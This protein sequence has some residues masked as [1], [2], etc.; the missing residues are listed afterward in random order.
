VNSEYGLDSRL[1]GNDEKEKRMVKGAVERL[2]E[3]PV[4]TGK[5]E[6]DVRKDKEERLRIMEAGITG[7]NEVLT[8]EYIDHM[9][10]RF[11]G[12]KIRELTHVKFEQ[13]LES[14]D[15][16]DQYA[17]ALKAGNGLQFFS[18]EVPQ[19]KIIPFKCN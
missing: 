5:L 9:A 11:I 12:G 7:W 1:R 16:F 19:V 10:E 13:Y 3:K 4:D 14:P 6:R 8:E 2:L 17:E 15:C 18:V